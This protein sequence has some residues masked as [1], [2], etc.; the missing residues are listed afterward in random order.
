MTVKLRP[1]HFATPSLGRRVSFVGPLY[2]I[3]HDLLEI[4]AVAVGAR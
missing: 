3:G 4:D 2:R 1:E